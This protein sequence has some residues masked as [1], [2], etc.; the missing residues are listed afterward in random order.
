[1]AE[2][3]DTNIFYRPPTPGLDPKDFVTTVNPMLRLNRNGDYASGFLI[4]GGFSETYVKNP[5]LNYLGTNDRLSLN[6]DNSIKRLLPNA[7]LSVF[8]NFSYTPL[9]PGFANP[10]AGT[11]PSDPSNIQNVYA[12]GF[13]GARTNNLINNAT[14]STSYATTAS[15]SLNA[16]YTY[17][18]IRFGS[19]P[20]TQ[21][22]NLFNTTSQIGTV[23][24]T[25]QLSMADTLS[26]KYS[27]VQTEST[28]NSPSS[29]VTSTLFKIDTAT[30]GWSRTLTPNLK[31]EVGGG[32]ILVNSV[33]ASYAANA[34]L[35]MNYL[36]NTA[37]ISYAHTAFPTF[38]GG[39]VLIGDSFALS[40]TQRIDRQWQLTE[41]AS[42]AH[43]S[44]ANGLNPLTYDSYVAGGDIQYWVTSVW[45][46]TLSY[47]YAKFSTKSGSV[48][49]DF[50][51]QV[52]MFSVVATWS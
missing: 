22:L 40:A 47:S 42:Y 45:S 27:H 4:V 37:T 14:A 51:R 11:S 21:G 50:D 36:I 23:G 33:Q 32:G 8:D 2:R 30:I 6:L 25:A 10:A 24:G 1:M 34:A 26:V 18:I 43:T 35:R 20:S 49:T 29:S 7:S 52:I 44:S 12:Q 28:P 16:S 13:L 19:S 31:A 41:S 15:T 9:P 39:G 5:D 38:Y 17:A 3:Y 48:T 46:T